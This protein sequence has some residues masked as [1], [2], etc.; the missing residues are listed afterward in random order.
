MPTDQDA[1]YERIALEYGGAMAR[2]AA[3]YEFHPEQRRDLLQE[4][5]VAIWRSLALFQHQC[6][7][8]TWIYRVA[9]NT[10]S[11]HVLRNRRAAARTLCDLDELTNETAGQYPEVL[12]DRERTVERLRELI[13]RLQPLDRQVFLLYLE[14]IDA[15]SIA[16]IVGISPG[17]VATKVHR[18]KALL[19]RQFHV[20]ETSH[21]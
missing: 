9:H 11:T 8:R 15:A 10:A 4:I 21:A 16:V 14:D 7:E 1:W 19:N 2:L 13:R 17:N 20:T 18:I 3:A 12:A 6:S 5:H